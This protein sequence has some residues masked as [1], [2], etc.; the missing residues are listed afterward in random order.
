VSADSTSHGQA[1]EHRG[2]ASI[3]PRRF[4]AG[5]ALLLT[6]TLAAVSYLV[7][8]NC[9]D[10]L[11]HL[12]DFETYNFYHTF[13][14]RAAKTSPHAADWRPLQYTTSHALYFIAKGHEHL[15]FKGLLAACVAATGWLFARLTPVKTWSDAAAAATALMILYGHQSFAGAVEGVYPWGVEIVLVICE[16]IVLRILVQERPSPGSDVAVVAI[17]LFAILLNEKGGLVG[18]TYIAG[19][20][21]RLPGASRRGAIA[22]FLIYVVVAAARFGYFRSIAGLGGRSSARSASDIAFDLVAPALNLLISDPRFGRFRTFPQAFV[23][24]HPWAIITVASSLATLAVL[25]AWTA[26]TLERDNISIELRVA[27]L[28]PVLLAGSM[29]FGAFSQKD[30]IP[31]MALP[32]YALA[33][34]Y[35]M[36]WLLARGA[37]PV[38]VAVG[39]VLIAGWGIRAAGLFYYLD[40]MAYN[41]QEEWDDGEQHARF[42][43]YDRAMGM[44]ILERLRKQA[45]TPRLTHIDE[46][47]PQ[48]LILMLRGR[49]C[50]EFCGNYD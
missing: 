14:D 45:N 34:F 6:A 3:S 17:S 26:R 11:Q 22:V 16:L 48:W 18:A 24:G 13:Y 7:P 20:L 29:M 25:V 27:A 35:A 10:F 36:R 38:A 15:V 39:I 37:K 41:Y 42:H 46:L 8:L 1:A 31:I 47:L 33:S 21:L 44:P 30:Y 9:N 32:V 4:F 43:V 12:L 19:A 2:L 5:F 50:P 40:R 49:G 23:W 28:L